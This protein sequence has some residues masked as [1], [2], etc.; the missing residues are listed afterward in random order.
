MKSV[1]TS[2]SARETGAG[3]NPAAPGTVT[4]AILHKVGAAAIAGNIVEWFDFA[5][6]G[7]FAPSLAAAFFPAG[8]KSVAL[9]QTFAIFA[10]AFLLRPVGG[11]YFGSL[12][13]RIGRKRVLAATV[14]LMSV[15]TA[16]V[17]VLPTYAAIGIMAPVLLT[18]ARCLQGFS[19]G[20]EY[21]G[22]CTYLVEHAPIEKRARY[23]SLLPLATFASFALAAL[24]SYVLSVILDHAAIMDWGWRVPFLAAAP[25]GL[26]GM[27]IRNRLGESPV[28]EAATHN[29]H[30][31]RIGLRATLR[32]QW[33]PMIQLG[34]FISLTAV[35]FY[36]FSTYMTTF[37]RVVV[38]MHADTVFLSNVI[39]LLGAAALSPVIGLIADR[40]G[41]RT[42][43]IAACVCL[44]GLAV[45]AYL[46]GG[47][48]TIGA[49]IAAQLM[50]AVGAVTANVVT[51]VLLSELFPTTVRYT[52][53]A[54]T[55]NI[56]YAVFGGTAPLVATLLITV[57]GS[58]IMPAVYI[59]VIAVL[60][61]VAAL[62]MPETS[63]RS[64]LAGDNAAMDLREIAPADGLGVRI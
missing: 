50:L 8:N 41:R 6:Y 14:L 35:S 55:Y 49:A 47:I 39:A 48:G 40:V 52:A 15:A 58:Y 3:T 59:A 30:V 54:I 5:I 57:T 4:D 25:M 46:V 45:P 42:I 21:A 60:A 51:A 12:G 10:V 24:F 11:A 28:F 33:K 27:Y 7:F 19:A 62:S 63:R 37:F 18:V 56:A 22:A 17:G 64:L 13:D 29:V 32:Q 1:G 16:L 38:G 23:A 43:M 34:G 2:K 61:L 36:T 9:L 26:V 53:S 31:E 44:G 20:G